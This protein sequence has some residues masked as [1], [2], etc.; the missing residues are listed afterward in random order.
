MSDGSG[1]ATAAGLDPPSQTSLSG[2]RFWR[3]SNQ[4]KSRAARQAALTDFQSRYPSS[5]LVNV[6]TTKEQE[7][8]ATGAI[9]QNSQ[10]Q[11]R[12]R[13]RPR[14]INSKTSIKRN[15]KPK[16]SRQLNN[17]FN[18]SE[19]LEPV[20][21][22]RSNLDSDSDLDL[23]QQ[24]RSQDTKDHSEE[25]GEEQ[26]TNYSFDNEEQIYTDKKQLN[27]LN[28]QANQ[29]K[30]SF[31]TNNQQLIFGQKQ[32]EQANLMNINTNQHQ[33]HKL[34]L[35]E[36]SRPSS[37]LSRTSLLGRP[38]R[39]ET[40]NR[41]LKYRKKQ[42]MIYNFLERPRGWKAAFYHFAL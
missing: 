24:D 29:Q 39:V 33:H 32:Q 30:K 21:D 10:L 17:N 14:L 16:L 31:I 15:N 19:R 42:T 6:K 38:V 34:C 8:S 26:V 12:R 18:N 2:G 25:E 28:N 20:S 22:Q 4:A 1:S 13:P 41:D 23:D 27:Q 35:R 7:A 5:T 36:I 40:H 9:G 37:E 3:W 11:Q